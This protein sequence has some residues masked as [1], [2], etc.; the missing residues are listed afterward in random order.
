MA[1]AGRAPSR[2]GKN[3]SAPHRAVKRASGAPRLRPLIG[4]SRLSSQP[5]A[6]LSPCGE[7]S[8]RFYLLRWSR[9][10]EGAPSSPPVPIGRAFLPGRPAGGACANAT[11][12]AAGN[13]VARGFRGEFRPR[14]RVAASHHRQFEPRSGCRHEPATTRAGGVRA[15]AKTISRRA[16]RGRD[17]ACPWLPQQPCEAI[18]ATRRLRRRGAHQACTGRRRT[19]P[20]S[21]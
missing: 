10:L 1:G 9:R 5:L 8:P 4:G 16:R 6:T 3:A 17:A 7:P 15:R 11:W 20:E 19:N 21:S 2:R 12:C 14:V 13:R 18:I